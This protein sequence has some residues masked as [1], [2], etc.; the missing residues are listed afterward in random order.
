MDLLLQLNS[1]KNITYFLV[2]EKMK[3]EV[4]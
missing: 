3:V 2:V 4:L 1:K